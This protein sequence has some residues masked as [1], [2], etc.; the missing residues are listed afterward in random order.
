PGYDV[1]HYGLTIAGEPFIP[2]LTKPSSKDFIFLTLSGQRSTSP[3]NE[4]ATVP[5]DPERAG[6]FS[7]LVGTNGALIP[8]YNP[9]TPGTAFPNNL[10]PPSLINPVAVALL[11]YYPAPNILGTT[12][13]NYRLLTTSGTNT[14]VLGIR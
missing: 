6:D 5:T 9:A 12:T 11:N 10:I 2:K 3:L 1:N 4:Y 8:I 14:D 7:D 13:Q